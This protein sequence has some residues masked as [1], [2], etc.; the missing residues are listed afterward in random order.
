[1]PQVYMKGTFVTGAAYPAD[2]ER[3]S[4]I[5]KGMRLTSSPIVKR[6]VHDVPT[7]SALELAI[8]EIAGRLRTARL[9]LE[10]G[11]AKRK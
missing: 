10:T 3:R 6:H 4:R 11:K 2:D 7:G 9:N 8:S 1:M 5:Q